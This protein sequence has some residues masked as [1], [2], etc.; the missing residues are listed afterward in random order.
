MPERLEEEIVPPEPL[1]LEVPSP[2]TVTLPVKFARLMPCVAPLVE[3]DLMVTAMPVT[4]APLSAVA[5]PVE[6][7]IPETDTL[8]ARVSVP[9][10]VGVFPD[11][12][13]T[14]RIGE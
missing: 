12:P 14:V 9:P 11:A 10:S 3:I 7:L 13:A 4:E 5:L 1:L 6:R 2:L 8:L